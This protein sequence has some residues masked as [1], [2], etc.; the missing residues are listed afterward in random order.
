MSTLVA[1]RLAQ[2]TPCTIS[3]FATDYGF[4]L[5]TT[6]PLDLT[7]ADWRRLLSTDKLLEDV[8]AC[9]NATELARRQFRDIAWWRA[10][11]RGLSGRWPQE[12][13]PVTGIQ[14]HHL[15]RLPAVRPR[16]TCCLTRPARQVLQQQL[17]LVRW[18]R[19][20]WPSHTRHR[21]DADAV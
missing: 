10:H 12:H 7:E 15:R 13:A 21:A 1:Y 16:R 8:L 4:E 17:D 14:R 18:R 20:W 19:R 5:L 6:T 2:D 3:A 9:V 11:L